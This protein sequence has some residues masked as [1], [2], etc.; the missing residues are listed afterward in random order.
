VRLHLDDPKPRLGRRE[1]RLFAHGKTELA[2]FGA[3][4]TTHT[5]PRIPSIKICFRARA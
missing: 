1:V 4:Q 2:L 3:H 5:A